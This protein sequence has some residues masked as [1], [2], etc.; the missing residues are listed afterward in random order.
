VPKAEEARVT[1]ASARPSISARGSAT[2]SASRRRTGWRSHWGC[3]YYQFSQH[4][5]NLEEIS[6]LHQ[7]GLTVE[8]AML[9]ATRNGAQLC[10]VSGEP[11]RIA[12]GFLFDAIVLD[13]DPGDPVI[14]EQPGAVAGVFKA[15][16]LVV[17]HPRLSGG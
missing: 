8:E 6:L 3:D 16:V 10:G 12:P 15:G 9:A 7:A 2:R 14:F 5:R 4:G 13:A 11:G 17:P 1:T